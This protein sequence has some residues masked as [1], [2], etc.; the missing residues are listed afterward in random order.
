[1]R[2]SALLFLATL[3]NPAGILSLPQGCEKWFVFHPS[4]CER[5]SVY[6]RWCSQGGPRICKIINPRALNDCDE[7]DCS[8]EKEVTRAPRTRRPFTPPT[9]TRRPPM[10]PTRTRRPF[11]PTSRMIINSVRRTTLAPRIRNAPTLSTK[12]RPH[13]GG[14]NKKAVQ[15]D[16]IASN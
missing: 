2:A 10:L 8:S 7:D 11:T 5:G 6:L 16:C 1:M 13:Y 3:A 9:R 12:F 4:R 15:N 14:S